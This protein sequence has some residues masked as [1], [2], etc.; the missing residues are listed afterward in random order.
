MAERL[1]VNQLVILVT[2]VLLVYFGVQAIFSYLNARLRATPGANLEVVGAS[3]TSE[4]TGDGGPPLIDD[5]RDLLVPNVHGVMLKDWGII[6]LDYA[7]SQR[8]SVPGVTYEVLRHQSPSIVR[9]KGFMSKGEAKALIELMAPRMAPSLTITNDTGAHVR[10]PGRTSFTALVP[11]DLTPLTEALVERAARVTGTLP[12]FVET[13]QIVRYLP[14]QDFKHHHD[15]INSPDLVGKVGQR[16]KTLFVYLS[17]RPE[18]EEGGTTHFPRLD[19]P[20]DWEKAP[21]RGEANLWCEAGEGLMWLNTRPDK[22]RDWR[23]LHAG[24]PPTKGVKW[25]LNIWVRT[26]T[27][28]EKI[29]WLKKMGHGEAKLE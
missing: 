13:L 10:D 27:H 26:K 29:P 2:V 16:T 18:G 1:T 28:Q 4:S 15:F 11:H 24:T 23:T 3:G 7:F 6:P 9:V 17:E 20:A 21:T 25:G 12:Q 5:L 19:T 8:L 14:G 22:T